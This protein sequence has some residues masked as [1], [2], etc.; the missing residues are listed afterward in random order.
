MYN[1]NVGRRLKVDALYERLITLPLHPN[2]ELS[3]I[4]YISRSLMAIL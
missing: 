4:K 1:N 3:D 2:L